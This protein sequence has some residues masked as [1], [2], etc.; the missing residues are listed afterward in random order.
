VI[1]HATVPFE[2]PRRD[3]AEL[4]AE[5]RSIFDQMNLRRSVRDFSPDPVPREVVELAIRTASTAP[6]GAHRQPWTFVLVGDTDVKREIRIAAETEERENYEGGRLPEEW[7]RAL[8][9]LGTTW[10]KPYLET[11]PWLVVVFEQRYGIDEG[12]AVEHN[13]YVKES[14]GIACGILIATLHRLGLATLTHTPSPMAFL[15]RILGRPRNERP[16]ILFPVGYPAPD[17]RVP[18]LRR[19]ELAEV[20]VEVRAGDLP[21]EAAGDGDDRP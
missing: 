5:A 12:G 11:A 4:V 8:A 15:A 21:V 14:V 20:M 19:K 3:D 17:C 6:S 13:Y 10:H 9:P 18:A 1:D 16:F 7:L 2:L